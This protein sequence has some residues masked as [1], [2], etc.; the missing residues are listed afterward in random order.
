M[1]KHHCIGFLL[2]LVGL[3]SFPETGQPALQRFEFT[4]THMGTRFRIV[5]YAPSEAIAKQASDAAF[6]RIAELDAIMSDYKQES[7]LMRLCKKAGGEP[8]AVS[9]D[10]F[11]VIAK[12]L[13]ISRLTDGAFD[14]TVGP[15]VRLWRRARRTAKM[16]DANELAEA[17]KLVGFGQ[18]QI[19]AKKKTV[20]L[21][22]KGIL[23]D[24]GG[25]AKG[26]AAQAALE[27]LRRHGIQ[28][29]LV[30]A[31]GDIVVGDA[32][33]E[34]KGWRVGIAPLEDP[35]A[36]PSRYLSLVN[37][38]VSTSGD[39]EQYVVINGKRYSHIV[40][41]KTGLGLTERMS[42]TVIAKDGNMADG[43]ATALCVLGPKKGLPFIEKVEGGAALYVIGTDK[44]QTVQASKRFGQYQIDTK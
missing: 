39:T 2:L 28:R 32:P 33:P 34:A 15:V 12:S 4:Q 26:Y 24:L 23:L 3:G 1:L 30:A 25:I 7:E 5:L 18:V 17:R 20:R 27:I 19:D 36:K 6:A 44:G 35:N 31:G 42:C 41:P 11:D 10:L 13:E 9:D 40:D 16:P 38:S 22:T 21:T 8:V 29:A 14:I 43:M 37:A